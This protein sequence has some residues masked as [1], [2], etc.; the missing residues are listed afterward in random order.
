MISVLMSAN[1]GDRDVLYEDD[2]CKVTGSGIA[3]KWYYFPFASTKPL[4]FKQLKGVY[5][6]PERSLTSMDNKTWGMGLGKTWWACS[7]TSDALDRQPNGIVLD[8]GSWCRHGFSCR[9]RSAV[10][11]A[12]TQGIKA[13]GLTVPEL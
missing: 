6:A 5:Y 4:L 7:T 13:K 12:I 10:A 1:A 11:A 8:D 3:I 9:D 2:C